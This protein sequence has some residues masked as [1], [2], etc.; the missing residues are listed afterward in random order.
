M[1]LAVGRGPF[2]E[3]PAG[4]SNLPGL[5]ATVLY[6]EDRPRR[7]RAVLGGETVADTDRVKL[8]HETGT[9]AVYYFPA[10]DVRTELLRPSGTRTVSE[11]KGTA[12]YYSVA[13]GGKVAADACC[14]YP[15]PPPEAP[16]L[17]GYLAF[18]WEAMDAWFE[19]DERVH[20]EPRD[21]Y[22]RVDVLAGSR[23]VCVEVAGRVLAD[24]GRPL[25][26][27]ETGARPR[28]Y[29]PADDVDAGVLVAGPTTSR[30][31]Y[32]GLATYWTVESAEGR[33]HDLAWTYAEPNA[34]A[35]RLAGHI[36]FRQ[37]RAEVTVTV[38]GRTA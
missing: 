8:L 33:V 3:R 36:C 32:K 5:P 31:Q 13:A 1:S 22:H 34:E 7:V 10:G 11:V 29:L 26:V 24:S 37:E 16:P 38:D 21:P 19:E 27:Y 25:V 2:G 17:S 18:T 15:D 6:L 12:V 35:A 28:Y 23:R 14:A 4:A 30:C 9:P 20:L